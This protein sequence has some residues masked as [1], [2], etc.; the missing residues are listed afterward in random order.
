MSDLGFQPREE[1]PATEQPTSTRLRAFVRWEI[2]LLAVLG[3]T[4][5]FDRLIAL[6]VAPALRTRRRARG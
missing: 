6:R 2:L 5:A 1:A 3:G 4:I